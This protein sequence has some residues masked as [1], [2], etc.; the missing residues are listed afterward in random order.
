M[1]SETLKYI[2][3]AEAADKF[4]LNKDELEHAVN[5]CTDGTIVQQKKLRNHAGEVRGSMQ[6]I[7][8]TR[9]W[10]DTALLRL[11]FWNGPKL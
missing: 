8:N 5:G 2:T 10:D 1:Q 7:K 4:N 3:V 11:A 9:I 6:L